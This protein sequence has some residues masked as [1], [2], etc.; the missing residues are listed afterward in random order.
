MSGKSQPS[1][2]AGIPKNGEE[3]MKT[4]RKALVLVVVLWAVF[5][6]V[7][8]GGMQEVQAIRAND[9]D[10]RIYKLYSEAMGEAQGLEWMPWGNPAIRNMLEASDDPAIRKSVFERLGH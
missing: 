6:V 8:Y 1:A 4:K 7:A 3:A 9:R 2:R 10:A 5:G